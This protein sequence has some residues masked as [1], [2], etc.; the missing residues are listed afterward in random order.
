VEP[1]EI[2]EHA[3]AKIAVSLVAGFVAVD[4]S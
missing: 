4:C 3:V 2:E 1:R